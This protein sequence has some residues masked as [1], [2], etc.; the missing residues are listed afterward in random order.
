MTDKKS[1][2][3]IGA[4]LMMYVKQLKKL[5][6]AGEGTSFDAIKSIHDL[7]RDLENFIVSVLAAEMPEAENA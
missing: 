7:E 3:D 2:A 1:T 6:M 5:C 4:D